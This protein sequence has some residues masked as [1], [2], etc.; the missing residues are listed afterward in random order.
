[1]K[2]LQQRERHAA[3][4]L[5]PIVMGESAIDTHTQHLGVAALEL[6]LQSFE[7]RDLLASS[8]RPIQWIEHQ[9]DIF[10]ALELIQGELGARQM[11][12]QFEIRRCFTDFN[13][14]VFFL[15]LLKLSPE[16][17]NRFNISN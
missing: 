9:H 15:F 14:D 12:D 16:T 7:S 17:G 10:L 11:A 8:G 6:A 1:M 3:Q 2:V 5:R 4:R 13:H